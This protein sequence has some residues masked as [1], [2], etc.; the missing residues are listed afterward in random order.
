MKLEDDGKTVVTRGFVQSLTQG[1][2]GELRAAMCCQTQRCITYLF[3]TLYIKKLNTLNT[4]CGTSVIIIG[5][6][7]LKS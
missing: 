4:Q 2:M 1:M 3:L 7:L 5:H 6:D